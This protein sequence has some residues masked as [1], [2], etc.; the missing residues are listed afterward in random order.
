ML[1]K[2]FTVGIFMLIIL[3][4]IG[5][6][7]FRTEEK[8]R[9]LLIAAAASMKP[10]MEEILGEYRKQYPD[11]AVRITYAGSGTLEQQI[12]QGAPV[13]VFISAGADNMDS[14]SKDNF[15][16]DKTRTEIL[17]NQLVL[18]EPVGSRLKLQGF[19][20]L[21]KAGSIAM[22]DPE[23]VPAGKYAYGAC[24]SLGIWDEIKDLVVYGKDVTEVLTWVASGNADA[25][26]VYLTEA[27]L[28]DQVRTVAFAPGDSHSKIIYC[29]ALVKGSKEEKAGTELINYLTSPK[30]QK[31]FL[32]YGFL[33]V[34]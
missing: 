8:Q 6:V 12:R 7:C 31:I 4:L 1:L 26:M 33:P 15:I 27:G 24:L 13:D 10:A 17:R 9:E 18:I 3:L 22:G 28:T 19:E 16:I 34:D 21:P 29:A 2:W 20:D 14:L 11:I 5:T 32:S 25:G 23:S 30:V